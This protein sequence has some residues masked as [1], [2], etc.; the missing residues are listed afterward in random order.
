MARINR[1]LGSKT[2]KEKKEKKDKDSSSKPKNHGRH[3]S[4]EYTFSRIVEY[5]HE[6]NPG[7][8]CPNCEHG[9]LQRLEARKIIR[10]IGQ[11]SLV[12]ELHQPE[13]LRC[14]GCGEIITAKMPEE[15]GEEKA[16]PSANAQE[17]SINN[18]GYS[19][20]S[21]SNVFF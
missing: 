15:V 1:L 18:W 4:D 19:P 20:C 11:P 17:L 2:E 16:T 9:T 8:K 13:R 21:S 7:D 10:I 6:L 14:S 3:G 12:A 5:P